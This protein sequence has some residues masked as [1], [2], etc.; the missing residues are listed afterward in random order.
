MCG[1]SA[2]VGAQWLMLVACL[3]WGGEAVAGQFALAFAVSA[4]VFLFF[5]MRLRGVLATDADNRTALETYW[6]VRH[7]STLAALL[8][9]G[10]V[11]VWS[12]YPG[13]TVLAIGLVSAAKAV[14][15][16]S[17]L[18]YGLWQKAGEL[19]VV[20][21]SLIARSV[22]G[23]L[24]FVAGLRSADLSAGLLGLLFAWVGVLLLFD[25]P[26]ARRTQ[27]ANGLSA[28]GFALIWPVGGC[29]ALV[30]RSLPLGVTAA[31][32][33]LVV[34]IPR[35]VIERTRG[36]DELGVFASIT[37]VALAG[38][39]VLNSFG[40]AAMNRMARSVVEG[41]H[42]DFAVV[43]RRLL[44]LAAVV[45]TAGI[46]AASV[47]GAVILQ[48]VYGDAL[49]PYAA[50]LVPVMGAAALLQVASF[51]GYGLLAG[52]AFRVQTLVLSAAVLTG[53]AAG[54]AWIPD[55]GL[56]GAAWTLLATATVQTLGS[57]AALMLMT[58]HGRAD[59]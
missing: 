4:P 27:I 38:G 59:A 44:G 18:C 11:S 56:W 13:Q 42:R 36:L 21:W 1:Q 17:D 14:E 9:V 32:G 19:R 33:V 28:S 55:A 16:A 25:L 45:G 41:R 7:L 5:A 30:W 26:H 50:L 20:G 49:V 46:V 48:V 40:E 8:V 24:G 23:T 10:A 37:T 35:Y 15:G 52:R 43:L 3:R 47:W 58:R 2:Y 29:R 51:L 39:V 12:G 31:L 57:L 53:L 54:L 34:M 6:V 22:G